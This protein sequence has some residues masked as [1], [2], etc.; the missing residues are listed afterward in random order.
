MKKIV[1]VSL[2]IFP[3]LFFKQKDNI[4]GIGTQQILLGKII[5][6]H[7]IKVAYITIG[8]KNNKL[9]VID[10][11]LEVILACK[12]VKG[13]PVIRSLYPLAFKILRAMKKTNGDVYIQMGAGFLTGIVALG[14][15]ILK[16]PFIF[17]A[18]SDSNFDKKTIK[19]HFK[20]ILRDRLSY[21][22]GLKSAKEIVVQNNYQMKKLKEN[23]KLNGRIIRNWVEIK[24]KRYKLDSKSNDILWVGSISPVK[25]PNVALDLAKQL[26]DFKFI[27]IGGSKQSDL[28]FFHEIKNLSEELNNVEVKGSVMDVSSYYIA[29]KLL[30]NT[31]HLEGFPITFLEAWSYGLPVV[32]LNIDPDNC[33]TKYKLG[34][35]AKN[36][37]KMK[38]KIAYL[39]KNNI[40]YQTISKNAL[41]YVCDNH[42]VKKN[43]LKFIELINSIIK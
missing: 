43:S 19:R 9:R 42:D 2:S 31:S 20:I 39:I 30:I 22:Y 27:F 24:N 7:G 37:P 11:R 32:T 26:P 21:L 6:D 23:F 4:G 3:Y 25:R 28:N 1:F 33:I 34:Y 16:K 12:S 29:S 14:C 38:E 8:A 5:S 15:K 40:M 10:N 18:A 17:I 36:I 35:V 13:I 41:N